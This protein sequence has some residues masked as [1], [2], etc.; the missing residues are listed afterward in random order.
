[1]PIKFVETKKFQYCWPK[2]PVEDYDGIIYDV[3]F[4]GEKHIVLI[5]FTMREAFRKRRR[6]VVVF[7]DNKPEAEFAGADDYDQTG[8][9]VAMIKRPDGKFMKIGGDTPRIF[10][11]ANHGTL[12]VYR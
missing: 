12:K 10:R 9:I 4:H 3:T 2:G 6:R 7:I 8:H 11:R 5:G 1:M